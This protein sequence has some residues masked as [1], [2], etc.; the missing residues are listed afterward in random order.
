MKNLRENNYDLLRIFSV[1][2]VIGIHVTA[3][4]EIFY[5]FKV[6][7]S[8]YLLNAVV[9]FAVPCFV[10]ISGAF[11]LADN[12]NENYKYFYKKVFK[13]IGLTCIIFAIAYC[14]F[15]YI[16]KP[17]MG[18]PQ[19]F[20][21][22]IK[23]RPHYHMWYLSMLFGL[24]IL[25]PIVIKVKNDI[26]EKNFEKVALIFLILA[27][28]SGITSK[29]YFKWDIGNS[30]CYLGYYM[31]GYVIRN[32][33]LNNKSNLKGICFIILGVLIEL[34]IGYLVYNLDM[35][36]NTYIT[37]FNIK[38]NKQLLETFSP[39]IV[40]ASVTIFK[41]FSLLN[42][43]KNLSELASVTFLIYLF[44]L[45]VWELLKITCVKLY[46]L[47]LYVFNKNVVLMNVVTV[48]V[49]IILVF[50][51]SLVLSII[52]KVIW[53]FLDKKFD[54]SEKFCKLLKLS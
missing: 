28:L 7:T 31:I 53:N 25:T 29:F 37:N 6:D 24:Y 46:V 10:M 42:I 39:L 3:T 40:I 18:L 47:L 14:V 9:R 45:G 12:R 2:A 54:L 34:G 20:L 32:R 4:T 35:N 52:Y 17:S 44:H 5:S 43:R 38:D 33:T 49:M 27:S 15:Q 48:L 21:D 13:K 11:M 26:G 19:I 50:I 23:G 36:N 22:L 16:T 8:I 51:I 30:F 41:G 1:I